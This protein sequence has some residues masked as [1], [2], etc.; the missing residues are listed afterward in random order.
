MQVSHSCSLLVWSEKCAQHLQW[1]F[2]VSFKSLCCSTAR[3]FTLRQWTQH[4]ILL[5]QLWPPYHALLR[6]LRDI[7]GWWLKLWSSIS[8]SSSWYASFTANTSRI[9][10]LSLRKPKKRPRRSAREWQCLKKIWKNPRFPHR[11]KLLPKMV[12]PSIKSTGMVSNR[13]LFNRHSCNNNK[14]ILNLIKN[15]TDSI[16]HDIYVC[17]YQ[18]S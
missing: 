15:W 11:V 2:T 6:H 16:S 13:C 9:P 4:Q 14:T 18:N 10:S 8:H 1:L 12:H 3:L 17:D 5:M 7:S